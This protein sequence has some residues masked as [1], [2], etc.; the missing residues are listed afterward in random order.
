MKRPLLTEYNEEDIKVFAEGNKD[1]EEVLLL[2]YKKGIPTKACCAGHINEEGWEARP[3]ITFDVTEKTQDF[4]CFCLEHKALQDKILLLDL[5][6]IDYPNLKRTG[7]SFRLNKGLDGDLE[8]NR[9]KFFDILKSVVQEFDHKPYHSPKFDALNSLKTILPRFE[10]S[11]QNGKLTHMFI[12]TPKS[13]E[14][15]GL[16]CE[17]KG[18]FAYYEAKD[19]STTL[20]EVAR[21]FEKHKTA[22]FVASKLQIHKI[23]LK[24]HLKSI[25][26]KLT[27]TKTEKKDSAFEK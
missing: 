27:L 13:L 8:E 24:K 22:I 26:K 16:E 18:V 17:R 25:H 1:L 4:V 20:E 21:C 5:L 3:Y 2:C 10:M 6:Y 11:L 23:K 9:F 19:S 12:Q 14:I 15:S 7:F